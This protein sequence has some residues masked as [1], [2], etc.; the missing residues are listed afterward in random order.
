MLSE[1]IE[2]GSTNDDCVRTEMI[3]TEQAAAFEYA[4]GRLMREFR[5]WLQER[6]PALVSMRVHGSRDDRDTPNIFLHGTSGER[7]YLSADIDRTAWDVAHNHR[8]LSGRYRSVTGTPYRPADHAELVAMSRH[9]LAC[10]G[11]DAEL[12]LY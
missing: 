2:T 12:Q 6:F 9:I 10:Q 4:S 1:S 7:V 3:G 8:D 11:Q 5:A